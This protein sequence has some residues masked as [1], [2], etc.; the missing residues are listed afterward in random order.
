MD[1][2][3]SASPASGVQSGDSSNAGGGE[4]CQ[5]I[6]GLRGRVA[7]AAA[8]AEELGIPEASAWLAE[9]VSVLTRAQGDAFRE[10]K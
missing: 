8:Q 9:A 7:E 4:R 1:G 2:I 3:Q 5:Q 10:G 6:A